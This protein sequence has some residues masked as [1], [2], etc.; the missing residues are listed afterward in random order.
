MRMGLSQ[1]ESFKNMTNKR[2]SY[3]KNPSVSTSVGAVEPCDVPAANLR[4]PLTVPVK[5]RVR[6]ISASNRKYS[7][8]FISSSRKKSSFPRSQIRR[9]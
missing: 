8:P 9:P 5:K 3:G 4:L 6:A 2:G 1:R 7:L